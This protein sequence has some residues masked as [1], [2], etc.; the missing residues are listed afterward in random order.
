VGNTPTFDPFFPAFLKL[1]L[2]LFAYRTEKGKENS[3]PANS[4]QHI[5]PAQ[6]LEVLQTCNDSCFEKRGVNIVEL[7]LIQRVKVA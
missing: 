7:G 4:E 5:S 3:L 1:L 2:P 6:V